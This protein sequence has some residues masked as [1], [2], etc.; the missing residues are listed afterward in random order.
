M[1]KNKNSS[2]RFKSILG[3][4]INKLLITKE[5]KESGRW[6]V[7]CL[8][9]CGNVCIKLKSHVQSNQTKS[10]GC[11]NHATGSLNKNWKGLNEISGDYWTSLQ[12][13]AKKRGFLFDLSIEYCWDVFIKQNRKCKISGEPICFTKNRSKNYKEQTAS[14]DRIDSNNGYVQ[15]N[16]CWVHKDINRLKS[17]F[18]I[19]EI[20]NW[21]KKIYYNSITNSCND[22][23]W[24]FRF[25][26][27]AEHI[28]SWSKD[29]ST[30]VGAVIFDE[31]HRIVSMGYNGFPK[32]I[33]DE[34]ERLENR[35]TK[36]N[37]II[38]A[39]INA[40]LFA[41]RD[42][43]GCSL[44]TWPFMPC[45]RCATSI[46]QAGIKNVVSYYVDNTK[47]LDSFKLSS[48]MFKEAGVK[49]KLYKTNGDYTHGY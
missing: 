18:S 42:L 37:F 44:A 27:L 2:S 4:K 26:N 46:I 14:L 23:K 11:I 6:K 45:A 17:D 28:A 15:D 24:D 16:I 41:N 40:I 3:L 32:N 21:S 10:C 13:N 36:L 20:I 8:C 43:S 9:E 34:L 7:E 1:S 33:N 39:E 25:L 22:N 48:T 30:K 5:F 19:N 38:H 47:W 12:R 31:N 35:D 49:V 29:P